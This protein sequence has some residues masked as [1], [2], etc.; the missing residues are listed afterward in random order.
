MGWSQFS[1]LTDKAPKP[2]AQLD[3]TIGSFS[4]LPS[5]I[6]R[7]TQPALS[8][9]AATVPTNTG[10]F[11]QG[12]AADGK[13]ATY[14]TYPQTRS[15]IPRIQGAGFIKLPNYP[16][17]LGFDANLAQYAFG[18][19]VNHVDPL[20]KPANDVRVYVGATIDPIT[21]FKKLGAAK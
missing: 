3:M 5:Y 16:F 6:C 21:A 8:K 4:N 17:V 18:A 14:T 9:D 2:W 1:P 15:L 11:T 12:L 13:T 19:H 20:N 7:M 10:C